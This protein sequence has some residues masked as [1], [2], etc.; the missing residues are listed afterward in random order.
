MIKWKF[1]TAITFQ[2]R[3]VFPI[4]G[5]ILNPGSGNWEK[6]PGK[7]PDFSGFEMNAILTDKTQYH[8]EI[9]TAGQCA[10][11]YRTIN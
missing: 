11:Y 10:I 3:I 7:T 4:R 6:K 5:K 2:Y 1:I 9:T 8:C